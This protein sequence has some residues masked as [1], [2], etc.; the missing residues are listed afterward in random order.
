MVIRRIVHDHFENLIEL[1]PDEWKLR[2]QVDSLEAWLKN[3]RGQLN[4]THRWVADIAFSVRSN[5]AGGGP[6]ITCNLMQICIESNLDIYLS[7]YPGKA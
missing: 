6:V 4:P 2:E 1:A 5:A 7:E 3:N